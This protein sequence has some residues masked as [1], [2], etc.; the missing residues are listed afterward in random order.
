MTDLISVIVP[1]YNVEPYLDACVQS[2]VDQTYRNLEIILVD[3]GSP[4]RCPAM[5]DEWAKK[6]PRIRVIHKENGGLS[7]AR[8]AG[9]AYVNGDYVGFVDSDDWIAPVMYEHLLELIHSYRADLIQGGFFRY[10]DSPPKESPESVNPS[11]HFYSAQ[12]AVKSI[13]TDGTVNV[14]CWNMLVKKDLAL[15]V[16]FDEGRINEDVLWTYRVISRADII[17][18]T[19]EKV[20]GYYQRSGSI[21]N[22]SY[23]EK[24][25]DAIYALSQ[26]AIEIHRD[27]PD[28]FPFAE[29]EFAGGCM[30]HYQW[31][32]RLP[33]SNEFRNIREKLHRF[34]V[35]SD[36]K[37][38]YSVTD[39]K[40]KLWYTSFR[41]LPTLTCKLRNMLKIGM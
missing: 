25:L 5:C 20:Y 12:Q 2:I 22:S 6:D 11:V 41:F 31:L 1:V 35:K 29:R 8:N 4:D 24:R 9:F 16:L 23:S 21:M 10:S 3:D 33:D 27:F 34:F 17:V 14:T 32:C 18:T 30:Y 39:L 28:L 26:R 40:Y 7:S 37:A 38:V 19:S 36:L 15:S 13:L